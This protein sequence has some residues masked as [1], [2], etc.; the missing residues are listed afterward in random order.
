METESKS[1]L[2]ICTGGTITMS[3]DPGT[4]SLTPF[5]FD[6]LYKQIPELNKFDLKIDYVQFDPLLDSSEV[7]PKDWILMAETIYEAYDKYDGFVVLHG[8]DTMAYTASALS[9]MLEHLQK[10]VILTGSQL[11]IGMIR[12]DGKENLIT[13]IEI[14]AA[15]EYGTAMVPEVCIFFENTLWRG[16]RTTKKNAELFNA[17]GSYNYA[18]LATAGIHIRYNRTVIHHEHGPQELILHRALDTNIAI[19]KLFPGISEAYVNAVFSTP[20]LR[21]VVLE[22]FGAGNAPSHDWLVIALKKAIDR[23]IIIL[24]ITQCNTGSVEMG[25]YKTSVHLYEAGVISGY[26]ITTETAVTKLMFLLGHYQDSEMIRREM[27]RSFCGEVT[28]E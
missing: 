12:T 27:N 18:A 1:V 5:K 6:Q 8:T 25:R 2:L 15:K 4:G 7:G 16:N 14:A 22:S 11:P 17:F 13:A 19:L 26:D 3:V 28:V 21:A 20:G 23:G 10:P 24:N 9:F